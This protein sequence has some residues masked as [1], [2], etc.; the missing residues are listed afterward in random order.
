MDMLQDDR[1]ALEAYSLTCKAMFASNPPGNSLSERDQSGYSHLGRGSGTQKGAIAN[2]NSASRLSCLSKIHQKSEH[3]YGVP[4]VLE[5]HPR[6]FQSLDRVHILTIDSYDAFLW[7]D[8]YNTYFARFHPT[9]T[10]LYPS[11]ISQ[12]RGS[13]FRVSTERT[14][15]LARD[16]STSHR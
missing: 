1:W 4:Y 14:V 5:P 9:L 8:V 11:T 3:L 13:N 6:H 16:F 2:S 10:T 12:P 15:D 7:S